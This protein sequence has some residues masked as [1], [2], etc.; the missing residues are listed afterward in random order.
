M[1]TGLV[2]KLASKEITKQELFEKVEQN[3]DLLARAR[4]LFGSSTYTFSEISDYPFGL[5]EITGC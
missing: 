1:E 5:K 3:F 4:L 2:K